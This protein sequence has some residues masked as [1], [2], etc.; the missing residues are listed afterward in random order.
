MNP[1]TRYVRE[2]R[3]RAAL[4]LPPD[5]PNQV[6]RDAKA[7]RLRAQRNRLTVIT[8]AVCIAIV[9]T[10]HW[11]IKTRTDRQNLELWSKAAQQIAAVE[12]TI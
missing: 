11:I 3:R 9:L 5:F 4:H 7:R 12:R 8:T 2:L 6:V 10:A 1:E